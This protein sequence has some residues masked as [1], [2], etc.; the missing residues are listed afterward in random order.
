MAGGAQPGEH[1]RAVRGIARWTRRRPRAKAAADR[2]QHVGVINRA[3]ARHPAHRMSRAHSP[4]A[5]RT[6]PAHP[7]P[8]AARNRH[9]RRGASGPAPRCRCPPDIFPPLRDESDPRCATRGSP[10]HARLAPRFPRAAR[11]A[12]SAPAWDIAPRCRRDESSPSCWEIWHP[13]C[14]RWRVGGT[15]STSTPAAR[16]R[17]GDAIEF[18]ERRRLRRLPSAPASAC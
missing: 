11:S 4:A 18:R 6:R 16:K 3:A 14:G 8:C 13:A 10:L 7:D 12:G 5:A 1:R 15:I 17:L 2:H 9:R